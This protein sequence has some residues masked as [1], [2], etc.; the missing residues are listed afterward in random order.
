VVHDF[1]GALM[2][3]VDTW[4]ILQTT[5]FTNKSR[6]KATRDGATPIDLIDGAMLVQKLEGLDL[7]IQTQMVEQVTVDYEWYCRA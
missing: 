4:M 7:G 6:K 1:R 3:R 5:R 2:G